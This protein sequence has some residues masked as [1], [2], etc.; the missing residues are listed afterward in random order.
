M[1]A[2]PILPDAPTLPAS[3]RRRHRRRR[4]DA[5]TGYGR[6]GSNTDRLRAASQRAPIARPPPSHRMDRSPLA[7]LV[8][9]LLDAS[10]PRLFSPL[11]AF[12]RF[13]R[14]KLVGGG[15]PAVPRQRL[16]QLPGVADTAERQVEA[17]RAEHRADDRQEARA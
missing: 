17:D 12:A 9:A 5:R 13:G 7:A 3:T 16:G 10:Y 2:I 11:F 15:V 4:A 1:C 14:R 8:L 6:R